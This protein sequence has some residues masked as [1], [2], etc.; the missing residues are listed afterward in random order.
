MFLRV[1]FC[2]LY[3]REGC[4]SERE[5]ARPRLEGAEARGDSDQREHRAGRVRHG[6]GSQ[7]AEDEREAQTSP[8]HADRV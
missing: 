2:I 4:G 6:E 1:F 8:S 5:R 3:S 7:P